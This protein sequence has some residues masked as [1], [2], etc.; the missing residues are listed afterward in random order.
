MQQVFLSQICVLP[1]L[2]LHGLLSK[3]NAI[4][5]RSEGV[6]CGLNITTQYSLSRWQG[7]NVMQ[8]IGLGETGIRRSKMQQEEMRLKVVGPSDIK[9]AC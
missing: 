4:C 8:K 5:Q 9:Y 6:R 1:V 3:T 7:N 2:R